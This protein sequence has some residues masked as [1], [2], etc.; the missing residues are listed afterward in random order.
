MRTIFNERTKQNEVVFSA[1]LIAPLTENTIENSNGKL[2]KIANIKFADKAGKVQ[3]TTAMIY[4]GNYSKGMEVGQ[5]YLAV[6]SP[7]PDGRA[8]I[9]LSHLPY[10]DNRAT[11]DMF[12]F[13]TEKASV[14]A[15]KLQVEKKTN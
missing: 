8:Y 3:K 13:E 7:G 9:R 6:A 2:F 12:S 4:E 10:V 11:I 15:P 1:E 5:S 14:S